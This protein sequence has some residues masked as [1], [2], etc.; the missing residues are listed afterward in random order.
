M[1]SKADLYLQKAAINCMLL[2]GVS[3]S[4]VINIVSWKYIPLGEAWLLSPVLGCFA[5][6]G[7]LVF[8]TVG[9]AGMLAFLHISFLNSATLTEQNILLSTTM[10]QN[11]IEIFP[12][13][14][15]LRGSATL[16]FLA[17]LLI[18]LG[19]VVFGLSLD[20]YALFGNLNFDAFLQTREVALLMKSH[21]LE[22]SSGF[23][24][25][26]LGIILMVLWGL[27]RKF[28]RALE[29]ATDD[30]MTI[31]ALDKL[32]TLEL[33]LGRRSKAEGYSLRLIALAE[34]IYMAQ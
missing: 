8:Q 5:L 7:Q 23:L 30:Q 4:S 15:M 31:D 9:L 1:N 13:L 14:R 12:P 16:L 2:G 3:L 32:T 34:K 10:W 6:C 28:Q 24:G 19:M 21:V 17:Y 25:V 29:L 26:A 11:S 27:A 22:W 33:Y 18:G 20:G